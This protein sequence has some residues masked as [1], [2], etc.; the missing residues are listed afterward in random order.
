LK[1][2]LIQKNY[3]IAAAAYAAGVVPMEEGTARAAKLCF[4]LVLPEVYHL[5][6]T[7]QHTQ[8]RKSSASLLLIFVLSTPINNTFT[9]TRTPTSARVGTSARKKGFGLPQLA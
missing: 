9:I 8:M 3:P 7:G 6:Q 2:C 1:S 5:E 4:G